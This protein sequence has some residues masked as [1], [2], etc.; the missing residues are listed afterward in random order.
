MKSPVLVRERVTEVDRAAFAAEA[1]Q[2]SVLALS[3]YETAR[4]DAEAVSDEMISQLMITEGQTIDAALRTRANKPF[5]DRFLAGM[6]ANERA[7]LVD[8]DGRLNR[9]GIGRIKNAM[10]AKTYPGEHGKRIV[11]AFTESLDPGIKRIEEG[12]FASL[13]QMARAEALIRMGVKDAGLS[14]VEDLGKAIDTPACAS[15]TRR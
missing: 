7:A 6:P 11:E 8:A 13:P 4:V 10:I 12:L 3:P 2:A 15:R 9:L 14:I 1:N 5:I